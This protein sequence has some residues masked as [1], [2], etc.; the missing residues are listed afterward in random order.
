[1]SR[2]FADWIPA[3]LDYMSGSE[4]PNRMHFWTAVSTLAACLRR[5]VWIDMMRFK[6]T[7]NFYIILV[8][9]PGIISKTTTMD[10]GIELLKKVPGIKFGPDVVTWQA[11]VTAFTASEESFQYESD[12][13]PMSPLTLASGELGNLLNPQ[14]KDMVNLLI[15]LWDG[16][17]SFEKVTKMSGTD[18]VSAPWINMIGCTTPHWIAD[19]MP[20]ATIGGGFIS[21]CVFVFADR[22]VAFVAYPDEVTR[23]DHAEYQQRLVRDLEHISVNL[24]GPYGLSPDARAW[25][26]EWYQ[27]LWTEA[28]KRGEDDRVDGYLARKQTH[29]HKLALILAVSRGDEPVI[30]LIDLIAADKMLEETEVDLPRVFSRIGRTEESIQAERFVTY[31]KSRKRVAY[32]EAYR[33]IHSAFPNFR[34]F[35][36]IIQGAIVSGQ[37]RLSYEGNSTEVAKAA[38][39]YVGADN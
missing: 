1:M 19:N 22:K 23:K 25:G 31:V 10:A 35:E 28:N 7:P 38:L 27:K 17:N 3:Y 11:L 9:P 4:A 21:R 36:G 12:W 2:Q 30:D 29:M 6:W 24:V 26:K 16:R 14:D 15:S 37:I 33:Y 13:L 8:A 32:Q 34:D 39:V 18:V 20:Q 5:K